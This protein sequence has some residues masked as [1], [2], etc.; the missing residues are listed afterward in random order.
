MYVH[1]TCLCNTHTFSVV[2]IPFAHA[3][4]ATAVT[5]PLSL[6]SHNGAERINNNYLK[7]TIMNYH[8]YYSLRGNKNL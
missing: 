7:P 1:C 3:E 4:G 8:L 6:T 2:S 5:L